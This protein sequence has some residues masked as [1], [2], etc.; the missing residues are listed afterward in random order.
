MANLEKRKRKALAAARREER[1]RRARWL[2]ARGIPVSKKN[3]TG[4]PAIPTF[5]NAYEKRDQVLKV[6]GFKSYDEYLASPLW[7]KIRAKAYARCGTCRLCPAKAD[8]IHHASYEYKVLRGVS[9][10][11]LIPLCRSCH[12]GI[13]FDDRGSKRPFHEV[14]R[15]LNSSLRKLSAG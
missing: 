6:M 4:R 7:K 1:K 15:V 5:R 10:Q 14:C 13:E 11:K 8:N 3:M 9:P 2:I 12:E